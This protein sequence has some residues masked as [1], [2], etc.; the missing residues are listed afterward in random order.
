MNEPSQNI[1]QLIASGYFDRPDVADLVIRK[2]YLADINA[3]GISEVY[4][5]RKL[6]NSYEIIYLPERNI[7]AFVSNLAVNRLHLIPNLLGLLSK[8]EMDV[9]GITKVQQQPYLDLRGRGVLLAFIDTGIDYTNNAFRYAGDGSTRIKYIWDQSIPGNPPKD[10]WFGSEYTEEQLNHALDTETP[11]EVVPSR[12]NVGHGTFLAGV[13]GSSLPNEY[14]GAAPDAE[15]LIVKLRK[16]KPFQYREFMVL[17]SQDNAFSSSDLMLGIEYVLEKAKELKRPVSICIGLGCNNGGHDGLSMLEEYLSEVEKQVGVSISIAVG[18]EALARHHYNTTLTNDHQSEVIEIT[19]DGIQSG[20]LSLQIWNGISDRISVSITSPTGEM[21]GR[22][23]ARSNTVFES[24]LVLERARIRVSYSFPLLRSGG[25]LTWIKITDPTPGIWRFT[26]YGD[27]IINGSI[28][29][30][31]PLT[32]FIDPHIAFLS[33][34]PN[35]TVTVPSA[36]LG[37]AAIGAYSAKTNSLNPDS[38]WGPSRLPAITPD[39]T[40]PG[41]DVLG[42]FPNGA[43]GVMSGTSVAAAITAGACAQM[44]QW[45]IVENNEPAMNGYLIRALLIRGCDKDEGITY[46]NEQWGYGK[47]NLY[48]TFVQIRGTV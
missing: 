31:L 33:P 16:G 43:T 45:G 48:N 13:A 3:I 46:P 25:Q 41:T 26:V 15:F 6:Q 29:A 22:I 1:E 2:E 34:S 23:P 5:G 39:L 19:T 44:L 21:I 38:S 20:G 7:E 36:A 24:G 12:D 11:F 37:I 27:I 9:S 42:I 14:I 4:V 10:F 30:W 47:L 28:H 17:D 35:Y 8:T 18:N 40:A 32:G